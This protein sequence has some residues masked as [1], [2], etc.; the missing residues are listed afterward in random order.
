MPDKAV[1]IGLGFGSNIGDRPGNIRRAIDLLMERGVA[2]ITKISS[3][4]RTAPWGYR[5]QED[6]ANACALATT[7]LAPHA[8]LAA[9]KDIEK[10]IGRQ[11]TIRWGPRV[12]DIDILFYD[13]EW[14]DDPDL[15]LPHKELF[16]RP[17]VLLPLAE[18]APD[19]C[20]R[21]RGIGEAAAAA[22]PSGITLWEKKE[23]IET[24]P[25]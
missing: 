5:E 8:L 13:D 1:P 3:L 24:H 25:S 2:R 14:L 12:I 6:F 18:I 4:Y 20:L 9:L 11:E 22:D 19:L 16:N 17:F 21:G 10:T 23:P 7:R 15:I